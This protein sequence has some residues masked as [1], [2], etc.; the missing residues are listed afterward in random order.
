MA[1]ASWSSASIVRKVMS[2]F[3]SRIKNDHMSQV[4][5]SCQICKISQFPFPSIMNKSSLPFELI[6]TDIWVLLLF[7]LI[8]GIH[9]TLIFHIISVNSLDFSS[10]K[11][12]LMHL[13]Y[14]MPFVYKLRTFLIKKLRLYNL[15]D[16]RSFSLTISN[17]NYRVM[18]SYTTLL[19]STWHNKIALL[20]GNTGTLW[21]QDSHC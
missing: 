6:H 11:Q 5:S 2:L 7:F 4:C 13:K 20:N 1:L 10:W 8:L 14:F 21:R 16:Q 19:F 9:T 18:A 17:M 3:P 12:E 15:V